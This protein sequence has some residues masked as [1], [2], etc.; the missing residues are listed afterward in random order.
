MPAS[1]AEIRLLEVLA[2][3]AWPAET[4]ESLGGW[5]LQFEIAPDILLQAVLVAITAAMLAGL[6]PSW[7]MARSN[8]SLA[9]R[10]E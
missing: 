7:K 6:Y 9:L 3:N 5:T 8:P 10:Q 2:A 1:D 4:V